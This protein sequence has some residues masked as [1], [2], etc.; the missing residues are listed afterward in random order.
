MMQDVTRY[1]TAARASKLGRRDLAGKTGTTND[2]VDGWFCGY[3]PSLVGVAWLGFDQPKS[4][5]RNQTGGQVALPIWIEYM[6]RV[7]KG[8]PEVARTVPAG[9]VTT[10]VSVDTDSAAPAPLRPGTEYFY[11]EF[12]PVERPAPAP[13][14]PP[15][16]A[17]P[18]GPQSQ[19][20]PAMR[21]T[22]SAY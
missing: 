5:G 11:K 20:P 9:I 8:V 19:A 21:P 12:L 2:F 22:P 6:G 13:A 3:M 17:P 15:D 18:P 16:Q 7:L 10:S 4:L 1:G 14:P